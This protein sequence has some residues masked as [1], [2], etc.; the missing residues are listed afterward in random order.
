MQLCPAALHTPMSLNVPTWR[1]LM[2]PNFLY[3]RASVGRLGIDKLGCS[4]VITGVDDKSQTS[5][6][7]MKFHYRAS[8]GRLGIDKLGLYQIHWP[9][10]GPNFLCNDAF[11]QVCLA[12]FC[13]PA[14]DRQRLPKRLPLGWPDRFVQV[15]AAWASAGP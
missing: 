11:V 9:A 13:R 10:F 5:H 4:R 15:S 14:F 7:C 1:S 12:S 2:L 8:L 6:F 3:Y